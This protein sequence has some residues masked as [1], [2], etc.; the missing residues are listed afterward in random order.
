MVK[1]DVPHL[2]TVG[3]TAAV[4]TDLLSTSVHTDDHSEPSVVEGLLTRPST[5]EIVSPERAMNDSDCT[6]SAEK[7]KKLKLL[8]RG[9]CRYNEVRI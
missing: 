9:N 5:E 2:H 6:L 7:V 8:H 4:E 1:R 3:E